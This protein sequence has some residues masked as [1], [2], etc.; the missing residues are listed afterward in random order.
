MP[1]PAVSSIVTEFDRLT[2]RLQ[3][4]LA[5]IGTISPSHQYLVAETIMIRL[6]GALEVSIEGIALRLAAGALYQS[7]LRPTLLVTSRSLDRAYTNFQHFNRK[8]PLGRLS[9]TTGKACVKNVGMV[10]HQSERFIYQIR[11]HASH[12]D[13][14]RQVRNHVAHRTRSTRAGY[15]LV[16]HQT[17]G[18]NLNIQVGAFLLSTKR[19]P[20]AKLL[21]YMAWSKAIVH[22]LSQG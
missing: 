5:A 17:F 20:T 19:R 1:V 2:G 18:A 9:W 8:R 22:G 7:G 16:V 10:L 12:L 4:H 3:D 11:V 15:K 13:E 14:M 21:D 6:F